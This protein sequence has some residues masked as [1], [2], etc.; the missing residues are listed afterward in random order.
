MNDVEFKLVDASG[1]CVYWHRKHRGAFPEDWRPLTIRKRELEP[2]FEAQ[3]Q[4]MSE[5]GAI[6]LALL[7]GSTGK[8]S[9]WIAQAPPEQPGRGLRDP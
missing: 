3:G 8:G 7:G 5:L 6:E 1:R 4:T 2:S 9:I